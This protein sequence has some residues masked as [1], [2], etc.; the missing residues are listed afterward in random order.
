MKMRLVTVA[1]YTSLYVKCLLFLSAFKG[2]Q[3]NIDNY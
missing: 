2:T 1:L 3:E